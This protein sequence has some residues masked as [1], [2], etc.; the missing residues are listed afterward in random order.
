MK[1]FFDMVVDGK[2]GPYLIMPLSVDSGF[3]A[4]LRDANSFKEKILKNQFTLLT[5]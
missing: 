2:D 3:Q 5:I 4:P 1:F